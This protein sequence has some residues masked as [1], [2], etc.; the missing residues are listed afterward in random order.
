M[1]GA[2]FFITVAALCILSAGKAIVQGRGARRYLGG[3]GD[4]FL[5]IALFLLFTALSYLPLLFSATLSL[6]SVGYAAVAAVLNLLYQLSYTVALSSG[7]VGLTALFAALSMLIPL[8]GSTLFLCDGFG[9]AR[10]LGLVLIVITLVLN[11]DFKKGAGSLSGRWWLAVAV[12]FFSNGLS[13]FWQKCFVLGSHGEE[14]VCYNFFAYFLAALLSFLL[15]PFLRKKATSPLSSRRGLY[16]C[17]V[18]V[19]LLLGAYQW[20]FAHAQRAVEAT[21]L[22]PIYNGGFIVIMTVAGAIL[23]GERLPP[24]RLA[25]TVVGIAAIILFSIVQ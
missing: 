10:I 13:A 21:L 16:L 3:F 15:L 5:F 20:L 23:F 14:I 8:F 19:G 12:T 4:S 17:A 25:A 7:P 2:G 9:P 11:T 18:A 6:P 1:E 22:Y 24:R